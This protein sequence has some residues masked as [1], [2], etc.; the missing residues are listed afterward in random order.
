LATSI[1][2]H[3]YVVLLERRFYNY[4]VPDCV[5][6]DRLASALRMRREELWESNSRLAER[7]EMRIVEA[8]RSHVH[9]HGDS[10][11]AAQC[12]AGRYPELGTH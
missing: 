2:H 12:L 9:A 5:A 11:L 8:R 3:F 10:R 6:C 4:S 7:I 1:A